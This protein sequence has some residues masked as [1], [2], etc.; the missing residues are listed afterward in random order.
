VTSASVT[1]KARATSD[2]VAASDYTELSTMLAAAN[3]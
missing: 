3:F 1:Y 2:D